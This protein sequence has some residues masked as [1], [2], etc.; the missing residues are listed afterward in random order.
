MAELVQR[1]S[2][3]QK[4][5]D[6]ILDTATELILRWGYNKTT[7]DDIARQSDVAKGTIYLHWKT[8][9]ELF[10]ALLKREQLAMAAD[11]RQRIMSD[12]AGA[13]LRGI[14][15]HTARALMQRPLMK[16]FILRDIDVL[17]K[18]AQSEQSNSA[19][20]QRLE[21][22]KAYL[23]FLRAHQLVRDDLN[24][25][26]QVYVLSAV[27]M[28]FFLVAP[29]MPDDLVVSDDVLADLIGETVQRTLGSDR[30]VAPGELETIS[31]TFLNYL[32]RAVSIAQE[33][34][35][36]ELES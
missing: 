5:A 9:E 27:F 21:G 31:T 8:R 22:F 28:G 2:E 11:F 10:R 3:R 24:V 36:R 30:L 33:Q 13:T 26:A 17:G 14:F 6:R 1:V 19:Y 29:L 23:E 4:R 25:Q 32:D 18:L 16:A 35:N 7:I 15:Q 20:V 12:P 34:F